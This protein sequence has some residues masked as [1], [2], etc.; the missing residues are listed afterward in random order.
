LAAVA[1]CQASDVAAPVAEQPAFAVYESPPDPPFYARVERPYTIHTDE[2]AAIIFYRPPACVPA[3]FNLLDFFDI[4]GAFACGPLT[5]DGR[6]MRKV[7][8][9]FSA[10]FQSELHGLGV[11]PIWLVTWSEM[12]SALAD[13]VVTMAELLGLPSLQV[14][15]AHTFNETLQP[16]PTRLPSR[17]IMNAAG[18]L[19]DGR[20][21]TLHYTSKDTFTTID[22]RSVRIDVW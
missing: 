4:P 13:D 18:T 3:G 17:L 21:F 8:D 7:A 19:A 12:Q 6:E 16:I 22:V 9:P 20:R 15:T 2:W 1:G 14:G 5:V 11:V 10:P